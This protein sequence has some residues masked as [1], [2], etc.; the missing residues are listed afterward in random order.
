[1]KKYHKNGF[2]AITSLLIISSIT[3]A[4]AVSVSLLGVEETKTALVYKKGLETFMI[5]K[6]C[7]EEALLRL[8]NDDTYANT[9]ILL[10][11]GNGSCTISKGGTSPNFIITIEA[12]ITNPP[13]YV[14]KLEISTRKKGKSI[15]V[16]NWQEIN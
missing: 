13:R 14:K 1:M 9:P 2:I 11:V 8:R 7:E 5:A 16:T 10:N 4:I 12:T 6:S 3:F 15:T